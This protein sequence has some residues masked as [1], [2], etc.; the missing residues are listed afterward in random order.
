MRPRLLLVPL[1]TEL[2]WSIRPE[3]EEW[4]DVA[5]FDIPGVGEEPPVEPLDRGAIVERALRE[6]DRRGWDSYV[7]VCDGTALPTGVGVAHARPGAVVAMALGHAR[8]VN[9]LDGERPTLRREVMD[10]FRLLAQTD[11]LAFVQH[12]LAQMTHGSIGEELAARM[13]QRIPLEL[14]I[15][16]WEMNLRDPEPFEQMIREVDVP[17][18]LAKHEGCLALTEEGFADAAAVFPAA[19]TVTVSE[20]PTV[21]P[22]FAAALRS[23]CAEVGTRV[24]GIAPP[25][26]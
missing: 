4:A 6:A 7:V 15:A 25:S 10:A 16:V 9:R 21:S 24:P 20:A 18:L 8:L 5:S 22:D 17:L 2:E 19:R 12:G 11:H 13:L 14:G 3:L 1:L 26:T 23:F